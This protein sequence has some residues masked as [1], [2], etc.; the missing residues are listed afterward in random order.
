M[1]KLHLGVKGLDDDDE[2]ICHLSKLDNLS[3]DLAR[4]ILCCTKLVSKQN[5]VTVTMGGFRE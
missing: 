4:S 3:T 5:H 1:E 2:N